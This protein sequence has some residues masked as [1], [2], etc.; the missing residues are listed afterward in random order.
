MGIIINHYKDPVIK[1]TV[2]DGRY[3]GF[4][5]GKNLSHQT[6]CQV[7]FTSLPENAGNEQM[8]DGGFKDFSFSPLFGEDSHFD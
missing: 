3:E 8:L 1:Q 4:F 6:S 7:L 5:P 2:F